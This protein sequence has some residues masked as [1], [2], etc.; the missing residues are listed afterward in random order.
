MLRLFLKLL[1]LM[2]PFSISARRQKFV[3]PRLMPSSRA[4]SRW[5]ICG[6]SCSFFSILA[7]YS[8]VSMGPGT[9][10]CSIA[11]QTPLDRHSGPMASRD[12]SGALVQDRVEVVRVGALAHGRRELLELPGADIAHAVGD[13]LGARDLEPLPAL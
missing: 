8:S 5:L 4:R 3:R 10:V 9:E 6:S 1:A 11:E 7:R 13:L 2:S 12:F